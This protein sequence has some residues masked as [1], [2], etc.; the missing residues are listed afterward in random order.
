MSNDM[1]NNFLLTVGKHISSSS[2]SFRAGARLYQV[3]D[4]LWDE[5]KKYSNKI[6]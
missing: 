2:V 1:A 4:K 6:K 3:W 5:N